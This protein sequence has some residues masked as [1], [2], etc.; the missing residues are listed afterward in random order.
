MSQTAETIIHKDGVE[1]TLYCFKTKQEPIASI[2]ILHGMAEHY[3]RYDV[4]VTYLLDKGFDVYQYNHRGHG[5]DINTKDLGYVSAKNGHKL[6]IGDGITVL[7]F[8]K[9]NARCRRL[10]LFGHSMGSLISRCIIQAYEDLDGV[11]L[12]GTTYPSKIK[13]LPGILLT[14]IIKIFH[15]PKHLSTFIDHLIFGSSHYNSLRKRTAFDW[16]TRNNSIVGAYIHDPYCGFICS[17][18]FYQDL[19]KLTLQASTTSRIKKTTK[20][21]PLLLIAGKEDPVGS[22]GKEVANLYDHFKHWKFEDVT[23]KLY[24]DCRHELLQE[25]NANDIMNDISLWIKNVIHS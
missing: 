23:M 15:G 3:K 12:C 14:D 6:M 25:L 7:N 22:M 11:I 21:L 2:L 5:T 20:K 9:K 19:L 10:F 1:T 24:D 8:I 18:S 17:V 13:L 16:L 4:F